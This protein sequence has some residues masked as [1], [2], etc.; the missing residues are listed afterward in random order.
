[1]LKDITLEASPYGFKIP[2]KI[3]DK[4]WQEV[5]VGRIPLLEETDRRL[6]LVLTLATKAIKEASDRRFVRFKV[7]PD[8][9]RLRG[10]NLFVGLIANKYFIISQLSEV[11]DLKMLGGASG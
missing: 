5:V 6:A 7:P 9:A 8:F 1:M 11:E 2:V 4:T 10:Y 3:T